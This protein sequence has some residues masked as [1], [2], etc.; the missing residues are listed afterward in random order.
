MKHALLFSLILVHS[1]AA[2]HLAIAEPRTKL[3]D[4][5]EYQRTLRKYLATLT[6]KDYEHGVT[7][8]FEPATVPEDPETQY[9][10]WLLNRLSQPL[11]GTKRGA[12]AVNAPARLFTLASIEKSEGVMNLPLWPEPVSWLVNWKHPG[13]PYYNS[14]A[15]K[16]RAF[17]SLCIHL[18][19]LDDQIEHAPELGGARFDTLAP[20]LLTLA[21]SYPGV[22]D[23]LPEE[24]RKAFEVG[25]RK[26]GRRLLEADPKG[27]QPNM[28]VVGPVALW[29]IS[30]ALGD[31]AFTKEVEALARRFWS[32]ETFTNPAGFYADR[33]GIDI[34]YAGTVNLFTAWASLVADWPFAKEAL[35]RAYRLRGHLSLPEPGGQ[36]FG[37]THFN[38]RLGSDPTRDQWDWGAYRD[39]A[40]SLVTAEAAHSIKLPTAD[41]L[42]AAAAIRASAFR[43]QLAENPKNSKGPGYIKNEEISNHPWKFRLWQSWNFPLAVNFASDYCPKDALEQRLKLEKEK[44]PMLVSPWEREPTFVH[45]FATSFTMVKQPG[46][47]TIVHTGPVGGDEGLMPPPTFVE[48]SGFGGGQ[49]SAFWTPATGSVILGRRGGISKEKNFDPIESWRLWPIHAVTGA[50]TE[51]TVFSS[52]RIRKPDVKT[53]GGVVNV[54]GNIPTAMF[55]QEKV[56][57]TAIGYTRSF[58]HEPE[59]VK[60]ATAIK[61]TGKDMIAELYETIPV[62]LRDTGSQAKL[63]PTSIEFLV[64]EKW[65]LA[66]AEW[67]EGVTAVRLKRF[68]GAVDITFD[69][70]RRVKLSPADWVDTYMSRASCRN[71]LIDLLENKDQPKLLREAK[72]AYEVKPG[73][74]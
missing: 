6:E 23:V 24:A 43:G 4:E 45:Q 74:K 20:P 65:I 48:F 37:P 32:D 46:Y 55:G 49:L 34:G 35:A 39:T 19:M 17:A 41:E 71:L 69:R 62:F 12:P 57:D 52:A 47:R 70:A 22:R 1:L 26:M 15:M 14:R 30:Q 73:G 28:V 44:S 72:M 25:L 18:T 50:T 3:P 16:L 68:E 54:S 29:Y 51:G 11:V 36:L 27:L 10:L 21:Y 5:H 58:T 38:T 67:S 13:N 61:S 42:K 40:V 53:D 31:K 33:G 60:I 2:S 7:A 8:K 9:R 63:T 56:L 64:N 59:S 66:G